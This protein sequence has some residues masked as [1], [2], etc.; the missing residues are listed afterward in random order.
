MRSR[1][2]KGRANIPLLIA[3]LLICGVLLSMYFTSGVL[4]RYT[5]EGSGNDAARVA[6]FNTSLE[7]KAEESDAVLSYIYPVA[8]NVSDEDNSYT[9]LVKNNSEVAVRYTVELRFQNDVPAYLT[10]EGG[11]VS[12]DDAKIITLSGGELAPNSDVVSY[13][14][15]FGIDLDKFTEDADGL[16]ASAELDFDAFVKFVQID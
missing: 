3:A 1:R 7:R 5:A 14:I 15:E 6:I 11:T 8:V 12:E 10:V 16:S 4:A 2:E 9:L 13:S